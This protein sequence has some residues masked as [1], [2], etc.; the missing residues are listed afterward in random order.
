MAKSKNPQNELDTQEN[1][2]EQEALE[3]TNQTQEANKNEGESS[4]E[5]STQESQ[6]TQGN[7]ESTQ[8]GEQ[9]STKD[10]SQESNPAQNPQNNTQNPSDL[11]VKKFDEILANALKNNTSWR[12]QIKITLQTIAETYNAFVA[13][14]ESYQ[15][16][17]KNTNDALDALNSSTQKVNELATQIATTLAQAKKDFKTMQERAEQAI[18]EANA[19]IESTTQ[20]AKTTNDNLVATEAIYDKV[21]EK[22]EAILEKED[23]I[24]EAYEKWKALDSMLRQANALKAELD[25]KLEAHRSA[26][27]ADKEGY[28]TELTQKKDEISRALES[29]ANAKQ[30]ALNTLSETKNNT[31]SEKIDELNT[32]LE[33]HKAEIQN[34]RDLLAKD[35]DSLKSEILEALKAHLAQQDTAQDTTQNAQ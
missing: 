5:S 20:N 28:E 15:T 16:G 7:A 30:E 2:S 22:A 19:T 10:S 31:L 25:T 27:N 33:T 32:Q 12:E 11:G 6:Q 3:S 21:R 29:L 34:A 26:L 4:L 17:I 9:E 13:L 24:L 23:T 8:N 35:H 14:D 1:L 18:T